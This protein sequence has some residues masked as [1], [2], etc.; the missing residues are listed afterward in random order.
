MD[1]KTNKKLRIDYDTPAEALD[2]YVQLVG[3]IH[4]G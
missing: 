2:K 4:K 1:H 3:S